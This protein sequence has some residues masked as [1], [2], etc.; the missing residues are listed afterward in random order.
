MPVVRRLLIILVLVCAAPVHAESLPLTPSQVTARGAAQIACTDGA[1]TL[2]FDRPDDDAGLRIVPPAGAPHWDLAAWEVLALDVENLSDSRQM[3]LNLFIRADKDLVIG[4]ALN[5]AEKATLRTRLPHR[6]RL[7]MPA[8]VP[9]PSTIDTARI[10]AFDLQLQ[11][12]FERRVSDLVH[13]RISA[14]RVEG[15]ASAG[16]PQDFMPFVDPYGQY[17]H[18]DWPGK[19]RSDE[20]LRAA[21]RAEQPALDSARRPDDW[22]VYGGW[23]SGPQLA[24]TGRFRTEKVQGRWHLVDPEGRLF[25]SHGIDVLR[26]GSDPIRTA[27]RAAWFAIRTDG[28]SWQP[29][30]RN[31]RIKYGSD[32]PASA[33]LANLEKRMLHW[34]FNS[35]GNWGD[36]RLME[37]GRIP[38]TLQ[39]TDFDWK[40]PTIGKTKFYDVFDPRYVQRMATLFRDE[41]LKRSL[42]RT[43]IDDPYCIGYFIDNEPTFGNHG[44]LATEVLKCPATQPAKRELVAWLKG[45]HARIEDLNAAW[46]TSHRDWEALLAA[47]TVPSGTGHQ[48][49]V[50]AFSDRMVDRY[51][52]LCRDAV[53]TVAPHRLYLGCRFIGTDA[54]KRELYQPCG[55]YS[56]VLSANI[57]AHSVANLPIDDLPD[58]PVL[59]GE[60]HFG[61]GDRGMFSPGL[62]PAGLD[63]ADRARAYTRFMEGALLHPRIVG[64]H[65]FQFRDQPLLGRWDGEGYQIGFVDVVDTPYPEMIKAAR[66]IGE[67]MYRYRMAGRFAPAPA[68]GR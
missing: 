49:D 53:K 24:A 61:V 37:R 55:R 17:A 50:R 5:P 2:R 22:N 51:F 28:S 19:V 65:W 31:L 60:F 15:R 54:V 42:V 9:G 56:D 66:R 59:I 14:L 16:V 23:R 62:C 21:L 39:L 35:V 58:L 7:A 11:W 12:P 63:D 10:T 27:G 46:R 36:P 43:S 30:D 48:A 13:C 47:Q 52:Q 64:A 8:G 57:Y 67:R 34:G 44:R 40:M 32:D 18:G 41:A 20:D 4:V 33:Y 38:Y 6:A 29:V 26:A 25:F 1:V 45:R 3:R 68:S